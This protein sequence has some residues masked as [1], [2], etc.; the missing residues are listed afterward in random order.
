MT[1][2]FPLFR[3]LG[4]ITLLIATGSG[5]AQAQAQIYVLESSSA[6]SV[7]VGSA[8]AL[9]DR[10]TIPAGGSVRA[11]MPSGKTQTIRGP[12]SGLV[13][14]LAKGQKPNEGVIAWIKN[15][16]QTGGVS[17]RT[18]GATR[19]MRPPEPRAG[20][21]WT[22][23]PVN[24]DITFCVE[25]GAKLQL[26]RAPSP[27]AERITVVDQTGAGRADVEWAA[28]SETVSWPAEIAL[29]P[30][31]TYALLAPDNRPPRQVKL[32]VLGS[33]PG[34]DD[35]LAELAARDCKHQF[36]AWLKEKTAEGK[37]KAS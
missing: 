3:V 13:G 33:L 19:S 14:D 35:V 23:V 28:G 20:F 21:S 37:R 5:L 6:P 16:L 8:Y 32:R 25:K 29:R 18:P 12:Y 2:N 4:L 7:K 27:R 1:R 31:A 10:I 36:D 30:D 24:V 9:T 15:L 17:E 22:D 11:V 26:L 34:D